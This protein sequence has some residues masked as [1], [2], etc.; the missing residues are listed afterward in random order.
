MPDK[1]IEGARMTS[2]VAREPPPETPREREPR[3]GRERAQKEGKISLIVFYAVVAI[4]V[5]YWFFLR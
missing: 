3:E 1:F 4:A 2:V 5:V